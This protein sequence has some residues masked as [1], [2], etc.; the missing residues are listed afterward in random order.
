VYQQQ[1]NTNTGIV[2]GKLFQW[3]TTTGQSYS[4]A[5]GY[6]PLP[7]DIVT[8]DHQTLLKLQTSTGQPLFTG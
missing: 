6:A 3:V 2:L 1:P 5:L 4:K 8:L 7:A